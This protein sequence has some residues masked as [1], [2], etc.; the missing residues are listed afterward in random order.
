MSRKVKYKTLEAKKE[1]NR[2]AVRKWREAHHDKVREYNIKARLA[3]C[4]AKGIPY[5]PRNAKKKPI[6]AIPE[7]KPAFAPI[8]E[9]EARIEALESKFSEYID[10]H[11]KDHEDLMAD[12]EEVLKDNKRISDFLKWSKK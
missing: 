1:A 4:E 5:K 6:T 2:I 12:H 9:L 10:K 3:A 11:T 8:H 7:P